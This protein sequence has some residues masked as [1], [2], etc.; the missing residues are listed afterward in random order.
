PDLTTAADPFPQLV[1]G[2]RHLEEVLGE[3]ITSIAY[4]YG[5]FD[6]HVSRLAREAGYRVGRTTTAFV[7][8]RT[9]DAFEM[10]TSFQFVPHSRAVHIRHALREWNLKGLATWCWRWRCVTDL[11][12]LTRLAIADARRTHGLVHI[13]GHS[14]EIDSHDLWGLLKEVLRDIVQQPG[15]TSMTNTEAV[16]ALGL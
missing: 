10:P 5:R 15:V 14:W 1:D 6:S 2:K 9:F 11:R 8:G 7:A 16:N 13:W 12:D 4:P 3:E